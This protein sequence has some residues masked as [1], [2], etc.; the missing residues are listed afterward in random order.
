MWIINSSSNYL[1]RRRNSSFNFP[2]KN[3]LCEGGYALCTVHRRF[4]VALESSWLLGVFTEV[5]CLDDTF[6]TDTPHAIPGL[7]GLP[8]TSDL[9]MS[10]L[11]SCCRQPLYVVSPSSAYRRLLLWES[12]PGLYTKLVRNEPKIDPVKMARP[13]SGLTWKISICE[14]SARNLDFWPARK[15]QLQLAGLPEMWVRV[16]ELWLV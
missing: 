6:E 16:R 12:L 4:S 7:L 1:C 13:E 10:M 11:L 8:A 5:V 9:R 3:S 14:P 2:K 15:D